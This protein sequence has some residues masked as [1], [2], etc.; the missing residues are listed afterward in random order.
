MS[1][2]QIRMY[3]EQAVNVMRQSIEERRNDGKAS[4]K[5]GAVLVKHDGR[6]VTAYRGELRDGDHAEFTLLERKHRDEKLDDAVLFATLEP[7]APKA[8]KF[9]KLSCAERIVLARIRRVWIGIEDPDPLVDRKGI[10]YLQDAG[11]EVQM[12]DRDLQEQI[13]EENKEFIRQAMYRA[14]AAEEQPREVVLSSLEGAS[15]ADLNDLSEEALRRFAQAASLSAPGSPEF[16]RRLVQM[17][18]LDAKF[19]KP[20]GF[21]FLL[22]GREPRAVMQQAGL[23]ATIHYPD[24]A[25][26]INDFAGPMVLIPDQALE[27][28]ENKLPNTLDRSQARRRESNE[29]LF[30]IL[31][32][33]IVNALVHRDYDILQA[34]CH[35]VVEPD[36]ID[37]RSPGRPI[38]PLTLEQ[39]Q[40]L[41]APMLSRNPILHYVFSKMNLAE[42]RGLGLKTMRN[43]AE[44]SGLP[45]PTYRWENPYLVLRI[46]RR[47]GAAVRMLPQHVQGQLSRSEQKGWQWLRTKGRAKSSEYSKAL[48]MDDRV[49]R[50]HLTHFVELGLARKFGASRATIFEVVE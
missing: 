6:F 1:P 23:L 22:F 17:G 33:G 39:L 18:L 45:L 15:R 21:G 49:G 32:E 48:G 29:S 3:M 14:A 7:C 25:E 42:E 13:R 43:L 16:E 37:I 10:K 50:R 28:L 34:K 44:S 35:L 27:W 4:P 46:L 19:K 8:R 5:V 47:P 12:F 24:G 9:P 31:R 38:P 41:N 20:S 26:E 36:F 40:S 2:A 11:V 30:T